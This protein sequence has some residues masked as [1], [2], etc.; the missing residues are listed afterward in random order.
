MSHLLDPENPVVR[1]GLYRLYRDF[2]AKA[3]RKRRWSLEDDIPW[4]QVNRSLKPAVADVVESFCAVEMYLPDYISKALPLIRK[5]KG[6]SWFHA[7]WGYEEAKHSLALGDWLLRSG[8]RSDE[9]MADMEDMV[10]QHEWD[11]PHDS[12]SGMLIYAMV[13][14][15]ATFIHYRNLRLRVLENGGDP[16]L[17]KLLDLIAIDERAHHHFYRRVTQL[18]LEI[19]RPGTLEQLR[20]VMLTFQMPAVHLLAESKQRVAAIRD[21]AIFDEDNFLHEVY[22]PI[23]EVLEVNHQ[24]LRGPRLRREAGAA[25]TAP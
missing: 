5:N 17:A 11:P 6:W 15:L 21:L 10:F 1:D 9:Q 14:E 7:N 20:R 16:A 4:D 8:L 3:E 22:G 25:K 19:D 2:F 18:F 13:Q 23:L 12:A 24:E